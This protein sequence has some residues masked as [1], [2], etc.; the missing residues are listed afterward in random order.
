M[1]KEELSSL[2]QL[3]HAI[4]LSI[5]DVLLVGMACFYVFEEASSGAVSAF[6]NLASVVLS[7][8]IGLFSYALISYLLV[9]Y[10]SF[11]KGFADA[12]S[13][14]LLT[15]LFY[16]VFMRLF[17]LLFRKVNIVIPK[18][19]SKILGGIFGFLSF[20][21]IV[22]FIISLLLSFPISTFIKSSI[23]G[24]L[25][26]RVITSRTQTIESKTK[27]IFGGAIDEGLNFLTIK[28]DPKS[29]INLNFKTTNVTVDP[30][31]ETSMLSKIN[32]IRKKQDLSPLTSDPQLKTVARAYGKNM[33]AKGY[34]S[35]Y[36]PEGF[37]PFDRLEQYSIGYTSAA[38]NLAYAPDTDFAFNGLMNSPG[39]RR[40]ILDPSFKRIGIGVIDAGVYG[41]IFVQEF[42]D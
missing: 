37:S 33:F 29:T 28:A 4:P 26:G 6:S 2:K 25:I 3:L 24:S 38:E 40:N 30:E 17:D 12:L 32:A 1:F 35:H 21:L 23:R 16:V 7:F 18:R 36:T 13:F 15:V 34:F 22:S 31:S 11:S 5:V 27:E 19:T 20:F 10:L 8:F 14:L 41:K 42:T 39:H 9:T